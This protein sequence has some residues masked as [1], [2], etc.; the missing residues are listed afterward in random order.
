MFY[1]TTW[2]FALMVTV[3][4]LLVY[5]GFRLRLHRI[6]MRNLELEQIVEERTE[7]LKHAHQKILRLEKETT[8]RQMAGGFAHEIRNALRGIVRFLII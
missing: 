7:S 3:M 1:E 8:E 5:G 4:S 6:K 2:F